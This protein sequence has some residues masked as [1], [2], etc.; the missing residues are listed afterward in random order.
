M[1]K[2][3]HC[4]AYGCVNDEVDCQVFQVPMA[5]ANYLIK[6]KLHKYRWDFHLCEHCIESAYDKHLF[7]E[8]QTIKVKH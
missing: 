3:N 7:I 2:R 5:V 1:S 8:N 4:D 6:Q